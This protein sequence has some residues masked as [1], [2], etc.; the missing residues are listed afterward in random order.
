MTRRRLGDWLFLS[1]SF[2]VDQ[3]RDLNTLSLS[4]SA[5]LKARFFDLLT[6]TLIAYLPTSLSSFV[7]TS[8]VLPF[9]LAIRSK[10]SYLSSWGPFLYTLIA[11]T[12]FLRT[13]PPLCLWGRQRPWRVGSNKS[14]TNAEV[15]EAPRV[16]ISAFCNPKH[17][18]MWVGVCKGGESWVAESRRGPGWLSH[19]G[20]LPLLRWHP[21]F[22]VHHLLQLKK[23]IGLPGGACFRLQDKFFW[24]YHIFQ[25]CA[26]TKQ[27]WQHFIFM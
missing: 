6:L 25:G 21:L 24:D 4:F 11:S 7:E 17:L 15:R 18:T 19:H 3:R 16:A 27:F 20:S 23:R 9:F 12:A 10:F 13:W 14:L 5:V 22:S 1:L 26:R 2:I 8:Q